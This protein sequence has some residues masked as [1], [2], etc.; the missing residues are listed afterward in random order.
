MKNKN[1]MTRLTIGCCV[2]ALAGVLTQK[3]NIQQ[4]AG[5]KEKLVLLLSTVAGVICAI[6]LAAVVVLII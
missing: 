4:V 6:S 1:I 3:K 5:E 2:G